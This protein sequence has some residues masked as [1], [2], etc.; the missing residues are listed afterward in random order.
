MIDMHLHSTFSYDGKAEIDGI[1]SQVQKLG[2]E[3]FCIT[4][5]YEYENGELVHDFNVEEYFLTMEKYDLPKGAEISW[6]GVGEAIFPR[7]STTFFL[8][9]IGTMR[10]FHRMSSQETI[11]SERSL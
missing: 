8:G 10:T 11:L 4:D 7:V 9:Y 3:H 2:I 6:D 5:H 1:I